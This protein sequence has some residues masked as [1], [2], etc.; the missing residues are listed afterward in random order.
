MDVSNPQQS[1]TTNGPKMVKCPVCD[2]D[3]EL[4][5]SNLDIADIVECTVCGG[6]SEIVSTDPLTLEPVIKG[7]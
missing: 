5:S 1:P 4:D 7:K 6:T 2:N 3:F